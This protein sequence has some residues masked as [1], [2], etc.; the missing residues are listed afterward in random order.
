MNRER[1]VKSVRQSAV[2][3]M[4]LFVQKFHSKFHEKNMQ[5][6]QGLLMFSFLKHDSRCVLW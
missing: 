3:Q 4:N 5:V 1:K 6:L 2:S